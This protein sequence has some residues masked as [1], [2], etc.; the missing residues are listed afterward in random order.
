VD[1]K[2][3]TVK[4]LTSMKKQGKR[5]V[6]LTAY[7]FPTA[8]LLDESGVDFILVGDTL[9]MV[10][11]GYDSTLPVTVEDIIH[12]TKAVM[13]GAKRSLVVADMPFMSYQVSPEQGLETAGRLMKETGCGAVKLEGGFREIETVE[14]IVSAGIP[15]IGHVGLTPQSI[16]AFGGYKVQ[17]KASE[18]ARRIRREAKALE[19]A[20]ASAVVLECVP[21]Q[22]AELISADLTVPTIGIGAGVGCDGQILVF[23]DIFGLY[24]GFS[25]RFVRRYADLGSSIKD[26]VERYA[27]DVRDGSF[28]SARESFSIP[29][30]ALKGLTEDDGGF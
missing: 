21:S 23:H 8:S 26:A 5:I 15:V 12:H 1:V 14:R 11:L 25:P 28:P 9:G 30:A 17:G 7:D 18:D 6:C 16:N 27:D 10:V 2:K 24:G 20:G 29:E 13:R 22:L 19:N 3:V 4:D